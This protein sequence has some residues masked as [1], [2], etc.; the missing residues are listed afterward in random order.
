MV[1]G[2]HDNEI[3]PETFRSNVEW[4]RETGPI[5]FADWLLALTPLM[6]DLSASSEEWWNVNVEE[7]REW[8]RLHMLKTPLER[9]SHRAVPSSKL[10]QKKW[11]RLE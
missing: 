8:Y 6:S 2:G 4:S 1:K 5:D 10:Q 3:D 11:G 7:A 9:L